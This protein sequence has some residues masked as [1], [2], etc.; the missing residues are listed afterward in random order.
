MALVFLS[1]LW[2]IQLWI[3]MHLAEDWSTL[4]AQ[5]KTGENGLSAGIAASS[6]G[7]MG[8]L[9]LGNHLGK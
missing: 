7:P 3:G 1:F 9:S 8:R 6:T 5:T 4:L 2:V